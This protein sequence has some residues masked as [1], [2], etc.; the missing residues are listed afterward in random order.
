ML[1]YPGP[2]HDPGERRR[3]HAAGAQTLSV[4]SVMLGE[5]AAL[6]CNSPGNDMNKLPAD[7]V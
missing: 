6:T 4:A 1:L 3:E 5:D 7:V 2:A